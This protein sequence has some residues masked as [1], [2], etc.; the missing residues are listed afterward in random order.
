MSL[1][2]VLPA[3]LSRNPS[4]YLVPKGRKPSLCLKKS[5][6]SFPAHS[7]GSMGL[8]WARQPRG[9]L[10]QSPG[11]C[12]FSTLGWCECPT[13]ICWKHTPSVP[14]KV[15]L[16]YE[17][18]PDLSH[19]GQSASCVCPL[20]R[21]ASLHHVT[22]THGALLCFVE[23]AYVL[24]SC[25]WFTPWKS[26]SLPVSY[27]YLAAFLS[28]V[29]QGHSWLFPTSLSPTEADR[30]GFV[31]ELNVSF[32][33]TQQMGTWER[34]R[35]SQGACS[36]APCWGKQGTRAPEGWPSPHQ[37]GRVLWA[38]VLLGFTAMEGAL[39]L[40]PLAH[41]EMSLVYPSARIYLCRQP[42]SNWPVWMSPVF[43]ARKMTYKVPAHSPKW[44]ILLG[45][46][47]T[48]D[49]RGFRNQGFWKYAA[50]ENF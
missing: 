39:H 31:C 7:C 26:Y 35:W 20:C 29:D 18:V 17:V 6:G 41:D 11:S 4:H 38:L 14:T 34:G 49:G 13:A 12:F 37:S 25:H 28:L 40:F 10:L 21:R 19:D 32:S 24:G 23:S 1:W 47:E 27:P 42:T 2:L 36:S 22:C 5:W 44:S 16:L 48:G 46:G 8:P 43:V 30:M 45:G 9:F 15:H 50:D 33:G 3:S